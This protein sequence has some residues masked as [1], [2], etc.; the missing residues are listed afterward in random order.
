VNMRWGLSAL[1]RSKRGKV[2][3]ALPNFLAQSLVGGQRQRVDMA[4]HGAG[5]AKRTPVADQRRLK[6]TAAGRPS[7]A[8][9][10]FADQ[11]CIGLAEPPG[12]HALDHGIARAKK[13]IPERP[14]RVR[15]GGG[16]EALVASLMRVEGRKQGGVGMMLRQEA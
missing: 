2:P 12:A 11:G 4:D 1:A 10:K 3:A 7:K 5:A 6:T 14:R 9:G 13:G 16:P 8:L 15:S